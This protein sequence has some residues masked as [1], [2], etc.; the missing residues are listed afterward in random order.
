LKDGIAVL[1]N[2]S[3][4]ARAAEVD[5]ILAADPAL[6][7]SEAAVEYRNAQA[8]NSYMPDYA[9]QPLAEKKRRLAEERAR[10]KDKGYEAGL[11]TAMEGALAA[12]ETAI[13]S[14]TISAYAAGVAGRAV[15]PL[16]EPDASDQELMQA[17]YNR[18]AEAAGLEAAGLTGTRQLADGRI[19]AKP[20]ALFSPEEREIWAP[21]AA[22]EA[23]P[24]DRAR[25][26]RLLATAF[27]DDAGRAIGE[28][29]GDKT[30]A[31]VGGGLAAGA[32]T[33][34][35]ARQTFE[36]QRAIDNQ[37]FKMPPVPERRGAF[38]SEFNGL[39]AD[40]TGPNG[41]DQSGARDSLIA[42]IDARYAWLMRNAAPLGEGVIDVTK[43][44]Q[45]T[46][47]VMGGAGA[48]DAS[49]ATGGVQKLLNA[50]GEYAV[51]MPPGFNA[52]DVQDAI[53]RISD[54]L[55]PPSRANPTVMTADDWA[56]ISATGNVPDLGG[57]TPTVTT[58]EN[59]RLRAADGTA[60]EVYILDP[61]D[62]DTGGEVL[63]KDRRGQPW[64]IDL[65]RLLRVFGPGAAP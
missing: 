7:A 17:F 34:T 51:L 23:A 18:R 58:L 32:L 16:P 60:Y 40:G 44:K 53:N 21:M 57:S 3:P 65:G 9:V 1:R 33:E 55:Q 45:A 46:H 12:H 11:V 5:A 47:D 35:M 29:A 54:R 15:A 8:L 31:F 41:R 30:F 22:P 20:A 61:D 43:Y 48:P 49:D 37:D 39:F 24:A 56:A 63:L 28:L 59:L 14:G 19:V 13:T 50:D 62:P 4:F 25:T 6:A 38:F 64:Q 10:P 42:A 36:G 26:A 52:G 2:G 27:G